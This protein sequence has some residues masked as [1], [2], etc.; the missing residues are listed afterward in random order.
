MNTAVTENTT[1]QQR[2]F[3]RIRDQMGELMTDEDLKKMVESA[4]EK[5]FFEPSKSYDRWGDNKPGPPLF[6]T[7]V[8]D[9]M[10]AR[11]QEAAKAW[12]DEHPDEV[13]AVIQE[14][15]QGGIVGL[16]SAYFTGKF[17]G[18]LMDLQSSL[19]NK[20]VL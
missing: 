3:E 19:I 16:L 11:V 18:P 2:M 14:S 17:Q 10:S 20:G 4:M 5:A 9:A 7:L 13:K 1:F 8:K 15:L 6:T 12:L